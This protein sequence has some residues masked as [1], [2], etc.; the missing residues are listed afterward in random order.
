MPINRIKNAFDKLILDEQTKSQMLSKI[1]SSETETA[2][3]R[4]VNMKNSITLKKLA[5]AALCTAV[6]IICVFSFSLFKD[7][8][9]PTQ[10]IIQIAPS[11]DQ[12]DSPRKI[13]NYNGHRYVFLENG[14]VYD[15]G[16][17]IGE[18]LGTITDDIFADPENNAKK[19]LA[20]SFAI[21]GTVYSVD[22]YDTDFRIAVEFE[23][24][25]YVCE[26]VDNLDGSDVNIAE[27]FKTAGFPE[28]VDK[29]SVKD[30][31]GAETLYT[32]SDKET[33]SIIKHL[34][35]V[36]P[37]EL[38][39]EQYQQIGHAQ[40]NGESFILDFSLSDGTHF[41]MYV[42]PSLSIAMI[43]DNRYTLNQSFT[44]EFNDLFA[45]LKQ[46]QLPA[47]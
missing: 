5:P 17:N 47:E 26:N 43:G 23:G 40:T 7:K 45:G 34:S 28:T 6:A 30:H 8:E 36:S 44:D 22:L 12:P 33:L 42:I 27:Y 10:P 13:L 14:A 37:A 2:A 35:D 25:Y 19:D 41:K 1:L 24:N 15:L 38:S 21:G 16:E 31:S 4:R 39:N 32:L 18:A 11:S 9:A 3:E 20:S 29:I 46:N